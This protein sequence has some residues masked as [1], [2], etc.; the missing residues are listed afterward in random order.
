MSS[1]RPHSRGDGHKI[2]GKVVENINGLPVVENIGILYTRTLDEPW[3]KDTE[4]QHH[5]ASKH[6]N[7]AAEQARSP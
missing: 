2:V 6:I 7:N 1:I 5:G 4:K 3:R